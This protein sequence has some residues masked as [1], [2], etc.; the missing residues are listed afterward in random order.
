MIRDES[1]QVFYMTENA[2]AY[3]RMN[4]EESLD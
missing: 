3:V 4:G 1:M 2:N